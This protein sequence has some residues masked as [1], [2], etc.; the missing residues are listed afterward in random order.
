MEI[1][2]TG[3]SGLIG[4]AL[5]PALL[6]KGYRVIRLVRRK[7]T[8]VRPDGSTEA[9][10]NPMMKQI[11]DKALDNCEAVIHLAGENIADGRWDEEKK[12]RVRDSRV[13]GTRFLAETLARL[14]RPPEVFI[15]ASAIGYYGDRGDEVLTEESPPGS[16]FLPEVC[17]QWEAAAE[18]A[19]RAGIRTLHMRTG[20][21]LSRQ[22]QL[23]KRM[24]IPFKIGLGGKIG[25]GRQWM[26]WIVI[27]DVVGAFLHVLEDD[28]I[29]GPV[30]V[31]A[32]QPVTN[33]EFT[34]TLGRVLNRPAFLTVPAFALRWAF[35]EMAD[36]LVLASARVEPRKLL[37]SGY[38][39]LYPTLEAALRHLLD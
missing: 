39:F 9:F 27:D 21:V 28:T 12:R 5:V 6:A 4:S 36:E 38:K 19:R 20:L 10:W 22:G 37:D 32:P 11:D 3:S 29:S 25:D 7:A 30:N 33:H 15:C 1:V 18:E 23:L 14:E 2:V 8:V 31:V 17:C 34:R 24:L 13:K 35:G 16:G 26:S